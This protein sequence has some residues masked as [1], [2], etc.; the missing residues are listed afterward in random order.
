[1]ALAQRCRKWGY[2][3]AAILTTFL[4]NE[5]MTSGRIMMACAVMVAGGVMMCQKCQQGEFQEG[6]IEKDSHGTGIHGAI[7]EDELLGER[8]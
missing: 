8:S 7:W 6:I 5:F 1:M 3:V 2:W 4:D